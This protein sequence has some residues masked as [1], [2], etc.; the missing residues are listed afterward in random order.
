MRTSRNSRETRENPHL[1]VPP[2]TRSRHLP[3]RDKDTEGIKT[4]AEEG[5]AGET[6]RA[7]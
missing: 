3:L 7:R 6:E 5:P 4:K 2:S 1:E